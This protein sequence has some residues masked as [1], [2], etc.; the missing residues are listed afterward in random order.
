V[1]LR[2]CTDLSPA[3]WLVESA[4]E[5]EQLILFGPDEFEAYARLRYVPDDPAA[6]VPEDH[7]SDLDQARRALAV[8]AGFTG[9]AGDCYFAVWDGYPDVTVPPGPW[10]TGLP[11]RHFALLHGPLSALATWD[12]AVSDMP[13]AMVWPADRAWFFASDVDPGWAGIGAGRAA[14]DALI[15]C[16][17]LDVVPAVPGQDG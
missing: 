4:T 17:P 1:S 15:A 3:D 2:R 9:T 16:P 5:A 10:L 12:T 8:L 11:Y 7:P 14:V 13:P 6:D